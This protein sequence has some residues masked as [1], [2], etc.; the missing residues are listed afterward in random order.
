MLFIVSSY[1]LILLSTF[2]RTASASSFFTFM[3]SSR[4]ATSF[5]RSMTFMRALCLSSPVLFSRSFILLDSSAIFSS[6][7]AN[8]SITALLWVSSFSII[9]F[10]S[11][12]FLTLADRIHSVSANALDRM[13]VSSP[14]RFWSVGNSLS[15]SANS[16]I[17]LRAEASSSSISFARSVQVSISSLAASAYSAAAFLAL[18][19]SSSCCFNAA[20]CCFPCSICSAIRLFSAFS[21]STS[22]TMARTAS[23]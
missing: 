6:L 10:A 9:V 14:S 21:I 3:S 16:A 17:C 19:T 4:F 15:S 20:D 7:V 1:S 5:S 22:W 11:S 13:E 18:V 8:S 2:S 12:A 23:I